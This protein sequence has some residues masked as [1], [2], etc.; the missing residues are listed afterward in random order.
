M[1]KYKGISYDDYLLVEVLKSA[2]MELRINSEQCLQ[3]LNN[4]L[5]KGK[6]FVDA[7]AIYEIK[8]ERIDSIVKKYETKC[9]KHTEAET[10]KQLD[11]QST[12]IKNNQI[13]QF[14]KSVEEEQKQKDYLIATIDKL[15]GDLEKQFNQGDVAGVEIVCTKLKSEKDLQQNLLVIYDLRD[16]FLDKYKYSVEQKMLSK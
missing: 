4:L 14:V 15:N 9:I 8:N 16:K 5:L 11:R 3:M 10:A 1:Y 6:G 13:R 12:I 7:L 2:N